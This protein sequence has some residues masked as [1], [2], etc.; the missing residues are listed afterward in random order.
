MLK[1]IAGTVV[2]VGA[3]LFF[4]ASAICFGARQVITTAAPGLLDAL[5]LGWFAL[6]APP[7]ASVDTETHS[8]ELFWLR[9]GLDSLSYT[10]SCT[11]TDDPIEVS[12]FRLSLIDAS[13]WRTGA[14]TRDRTEVY[15]YE[16]QW[17]LSG[18]VVRIE[19]GRTWT[20]EGAMAAGAADWLGGAPR[21][22]LWTATIQH[23][24][25][26]AE[27]AEEFCDDSPTACAVDLASVERPR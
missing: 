2:G 16:E 9:S 13:E 14:W 12:E 22:L 27:E 26:E 4:G 5:G 18:D 21:A 3:A 8:C 23:P 24:E 10:L 25:L 19:P 1:R 11:A 20:Y 17:P 7:L 6:A 15:A